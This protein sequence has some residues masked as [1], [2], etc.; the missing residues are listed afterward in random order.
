[1]DIKDK[2]VWITGASSG[3]GRALAIEF[4]Y[5]GCNLV[6]LSRNIAELEVTAGK[7]NPNIKAIIQ[8]IDLSD[9][10]SITGAVAHLRVKNTPLDILVNNGASA[11]VQQ[12]KGGGQIA[13]ITSLVGIIGSPKRTSYAA[14]KHALHG[15]FDSLRAELFNEKLK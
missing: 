13:V 7:C 3:I 1:M 14:S 11:N 8:S 10:T 12:Q 2:W 4:S 6:L 15:Y 5:H 9:P